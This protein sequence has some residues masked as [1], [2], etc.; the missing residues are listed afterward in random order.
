[1]PSPLLV[2]GRTVWRIEPCARAAALIDGAAFFGAVR[3][4]F[5]A[6]RRTIFVVG[7]DIDS[8]T[9]LVGES[10][11]ADG[12]PAA[13]GPFLAELV[14]RRPELRVYLLLW[15]YSLVYARERELLPRLSLDWEMPAQVRFC[16]DSSVA[17]GSSQHQKLVIVDDVLAFC[18]GL[19]L[20]IRRWDTSRHDAS[21]VHRIDPAGRPYKPFH[22]VQ[23]MVDG[24]AAAA[25]AVLARERWCQAIDDQAPRLDPVGDPWPKDVVPDFA[26]VEIGISRTQPRFSNEAE[27]HEVER[28]FS[29][30]I[31][32]AEHTIYV[33]NQFTTSVRIATCIARRLRANPRLEVVIVAP[34]THESFIESRTMRNGR[35]R[36]WRIVR[37]AGGRRVRLVSPEVTK[38]G[39]SVDIMIHSKVMVIDDWFL[40]IGSANLNNRS[41]GADT[42]CD[43]SIVAAND[44]QREAV[45]ALRN[46]LL[47]EHCG[48]GADEVAKALA[49][50]SLADLVDQLSRNGHRLKPIDDGPPDR[51]LFARLAERVADP[52]RPL[53]LSHLMGHV[54][55]RL[56]APRHRS[57]P[58]GATRSGYLVPIGMI[59]AFLCLALAWRFTGLADYAD[60]RE[61]QRL[62][63][64]DAR[65][66]LAPLLVVAG[67]VLG[68]CVAFPVVILI[69]LTAALFGPWLGMAYAAAG[70]AASASVFYA[71]GAW[72]DTEQLRQMAGSRWPRL[73]RWLQG[74]G[75]LAVVALRVLPMAPFTVVN[76]AIGA[77]GIS[78]VDFAL[79]TLI[80][81][82]PGLVAISFLGGRIVDIIQNPSATEVAWLVLAAGAWIGT[83][84]VAQRLVSRFASRETE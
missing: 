80:G 26:D 77:S 81:T 75:L 22:D 49:A 71:A 60:P 50:T 4:A 5:L 7:W 63:N 20:T 45:T 36:F 37:A 10:A 51:S 57:Q 27:A 2:P 24:E 54:V 12:L 46:R 83:A 31:D 53:R 64:V 35:I 78:F 30:S 16:L 67:F 9:E 1:M 39:R 69:L 23:M 13:F 43:L 34:H 6:A 61:L 14:S 48:V 62:L 38:D 59:A 3:S 15:D 28:L 58:S 11:P 41:M 68:G 32:C 17:F 66:P 18:G 82:G 8:R 74:R 52:S 76:L 42:E 55:P 72:L 44:R 47:G 79:G 19:D 56:L 21:Q 25:L 70:V 65:S 29:E 33:E 73:R 84:L 40:R